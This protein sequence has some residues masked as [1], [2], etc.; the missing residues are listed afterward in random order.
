MKCLKILLL[1]F[2]ALGGRPRTLYVAKTGSD[3]NQGSADA[4]LLTIGKAESLARPGDRI[5]VHKGVY[6]ERIVLHSGGT[7]GST[8][9]TYMACPGE[10]VTIKGS[11]RIKSWVRESGHTWRAEISNSFFGDF[12]PFAEWVNE[13]SSFLHLGEVYLENKP[14]TEQ[15]GSDAVDG[16]TDSW[17]TRQENGKVV[18]VANFGSS[19]P[20]TALTEINVR[21]AA[22]TAT[23]P[24]INYISLE[25]FTICQVASPV[26]SIDGSQPGAISLNGGTHWL[27]Q[28]CTLSDCKSVAISIGQTGHRYPA[29]SPA[30]PEYGDLSQ[31]TS[32]VGHDIIRHNHIYR[33]GQAGVFGLLHGTFSEIT[34]NLIEDINSNGSYPAESVSGI[35]LAL[36]V[37]VLISHNL[38]R[39]I[40]GG[41]G[42]ASGR[43]SGYG[44]FLGPLIQGGRI[45]GNVISET[46]KSCIRLYD[47]HGPALIDNNILEGPGKISNE[48]V[49]MIGAEANVFVQNLFYDCGFTNEKLPGRPMATSSFLPHSLVIKQTIPALPIDDRWYDNLF[50]KG[51]LNRLT[52]NADCQADYNTYADGASMSSW[53]D[54]HSNLITG[55]C[56]FK[57]IHS[58]RGVRLMLDDR[59]ISK[60]PGPALSPS[61]IGFFALTKQYI[62]YPDGSPITIDKDFRG[63]PKGRSSGLPGP[64]YQRRPANSKPSALFT[65]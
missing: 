37:D 32:G 44:I 40:G 5:L 60:M 51:G 36:A 27:V 57:L 23:G 19:D 56:G 45:T 2:A 35:R 30:K 49:E 39:R 14:L 25:G 63:T 52:G 8:G 20:N 54:K 12:N 47:S 33:C 61:F 28:D 42:G 31:D 53:G 43:V 13:D 21:P 55:G 65:Y 46:R 6:R 41:P 18:I 58:K 26:A 3:G 1:A 64:F 24:G 7:D 48:G 17:F 9:I 59:H 34:G 62:E 22:F 15:R 50:I 16:L 38:I 11:E 10:A 4:P 29:S